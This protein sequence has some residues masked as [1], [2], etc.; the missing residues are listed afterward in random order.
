MYRFFVRFALYLLLSLGAIGCATKSNSLPQTGFIYQIEVVQGN[1]VSS[2]QV[3]ALRTGM[4]KAQV[5]NILGTPL[6]TDIFHENRWDYVF[7][8]V[9]QG[10]LAEPRKLA[11]FF[12][13]NILER[14]EGDSMPSE[15]EFVQSLTSGRKLGKAPPLEATERQLSELA[16][17]SKPTNE[18][19]LPA[20]ATPP[21]N[22]SYPPLEP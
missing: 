3:A 15:T 17:R 6:L 21:S 13:N 16:Q 7:T 5:R 1:F 11:L 14:W 4:P 20:L 18:A 8:I 22:K 10:K 12:N 9:R 2:E 19:A